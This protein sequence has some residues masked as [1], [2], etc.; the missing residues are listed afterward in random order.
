M[1]SEEKLKQLFEA[2]RN[3]KTTT[4]ISEVSDWLSKNSAAA[5]GKTGGKFLTTK[6]IVILSSVFICLT[7]LLIFYAVKEPKNSH[8]KKNRTNEKSSVLYADNVSEKEANENQHSNVNE[9]AINRKGTDINQNKEPKTSLEAVVNLELTNNQFTD[10]FNPFLPDA[11]IPERKLEK[12]FMSSNKSFGLWLAQNDSLKIDTLFSGVKKLVFKGDKC[13]IKL[14]GTQRSDISMKYQYQLKAKGV[15]SKKKEGNCEL[16]YE[17]KDS[18]LTIH[19]Q[20]E[21]QKFNG[22]SILSETSKIEFIVPENVDVKM[23]TDL[24]DIDVDGLNNTGTLLYSAL[25]DITATNSTGDID[26]ETALGDILIKNVS[27]KLKLVTSMG[28]ISGE[29]IRI[30]DDC[31]LNSSMGYIDVQLNNPISECKLNL[32][33]SLGKVKMKR[34]DLTTKSRNELKT[35]SG[36]FK[37]NMNTS[38]GNIIV[39]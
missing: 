32:S 4:D 36:K 7:V 34:A 29:N 23:N 10:I 26:V 8:L 28:D 35:D 12:M 20:R 2:I 15:F 11:I 33:T 5:T 13:D 39:R 9:Q 16:S 31:I 38:M 25:G 30:S 17:L 24:G 22:I 1:K 19:L 27:G 21:N 37:V 3:E 18:V 6:A 14:R